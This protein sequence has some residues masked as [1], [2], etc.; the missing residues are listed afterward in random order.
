M[1][2]SYVFRVFEWHFL[3]KMDFKAISLN[4]PKRTLLT[5]EKT[6]Q[7][8]NLEKFLTDFCF[9]FERGSQMTNL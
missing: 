9:I 6:D 8:Y 4:L 7:S 2:F 1:L 3:L 5:N